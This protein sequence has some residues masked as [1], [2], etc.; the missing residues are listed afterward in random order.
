MSISMRIKPIF[1]KWLSIASIVALALLFST[2]IHAQGLYS[3]EHSD[4]QHI[5][6]A[7]DAYIGDLE[8]EPRQAVYEESYSFENEYGSDSQIQQVSFL[9]LVADLGTPPVQ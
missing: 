4:A 5:Q 6:Y 1:G 2:T 7:D 9:W 3:A 8:P